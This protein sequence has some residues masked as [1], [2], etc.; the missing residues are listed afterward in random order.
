MDPH[1]FEE[2]LGSICHCDALLVGFD[3]GHLQKPINHHKYTII[4]VL[5]GRKARHVIHRDGF[6]RPLGSRKRGV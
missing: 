6:Q 2:E 3:N 5:V 4:V 1:P